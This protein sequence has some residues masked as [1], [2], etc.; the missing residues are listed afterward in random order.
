MSIDKNGSKIDK[1]SSHNKRGNSLRYGNIKDF[2]KQ[3]KSLSQ[4]KYRLLYQSFAVEGSKNVLEVQQS[5]LEV[6]AL[7]ATP[8]FL[9]KH[10]LKDFKIY[11][12]DT[13]TLTR[14]SNIK[15]NNSAIAVVGIPNLE[16]KVIDLQ[17][18]KEG[19]L[20]TVTSIGKNSSKI[21][22]IELYSKEDHKLKN[23]SCV[24]LALDRISDPSNFGAI[25]RIADW[26]DVDKIFCSKD[27]VDIYNP[28]V[29]QSSM[30]SFT[31]VSVEYLDLKEFFENTSISIYG[32]GLHGES[33]YSTKFSKHC[34]I[35]FGN[36][37]SG[38]SKDLLPYFDIITIPKYGK[39]ESLNVAA[40]AA[41]VCSFFMAN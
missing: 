2:F 24:Y 41:V 3:V 33:I 18:D 16:K 5:S 20:K 8:D 10:H 37:S 6:K 35:V 12:V 29:V 14:L 19:L 25:L 39:A 13:K 9:E 1:K 21:D 15:T 40:A 11:S 34:I 26:F 36:E 17:N 38:I 4:K 30:G 22:K 27:T 28:K 32:T 7:I 31:R 23:K